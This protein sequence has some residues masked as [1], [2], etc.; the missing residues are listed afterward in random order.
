MIVALAEEQTRVTLR[1]FFWRSTSGD[2]QR[3]AAASDQ[4]NADADADESGESALLSA[5]I[6][7]AE[8][9]YGRV[10]VDARRARGGHEAS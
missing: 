3:R 7:P 8:R 9:V 6:A 10:A 1:A 4:N 2:K 5:R